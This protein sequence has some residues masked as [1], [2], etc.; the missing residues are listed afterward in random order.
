MNKE[1]EKR[2]KELFEELNTLC[3]KENLPY[4]ATVALEKEDKTAYETACLTPGVLGISLKNDRITKMLN[5]VN[6]F[7][8]SPPHSEVVIDF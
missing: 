5:V 2:I 7:D 6:G 8:T 3:V 4:F 1:T